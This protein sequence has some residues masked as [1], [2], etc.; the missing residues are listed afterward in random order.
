MSRLGTITRRSF[1]VVSAAVAG[2]VA[3]GYYKYQQDPANPLT[4]AEGETIFNPWV[5]VRADRVTVITPRAEMG[6]GVQTTLAA[7]VAEE[8]D[9]AWDQVRA[10]H[11]PAASAY[12]N[13]VAAGAS[14]PFAV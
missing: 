10:E 11:G 3:F 1:L 6:Q 9:L 14:L 8:M 2:G 12:T 5:I 13:F 7:L 4:A